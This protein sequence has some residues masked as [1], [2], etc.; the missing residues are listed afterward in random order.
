[1]QIGSLCSTSMM[2]CERAASLAGQSETDREQSLK[3][4]GAAF[5]SLF[6]TMILK[7]MRESMS[8][9]GLFEGEGSDTLGG[10]FDM[11]MGEHIGQSSGLGI[12]HMVDSYLA[13][14]QTE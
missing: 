7:Q 11:Y 3:Q 1:M 12:A 9:G 10:L 5:E 6:M 2:G 4:V 8:E 13:S 14:K